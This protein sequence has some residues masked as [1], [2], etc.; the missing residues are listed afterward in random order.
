MV[1][2][3]ISKIGKKKAKKSRSKKSKRKTV[4]SKQLKALDPKLAKQLKQLEK[5]VD[6]F[7]NATHKFLGSALKYASL[8]PKGIKKIEKHVLE[9]TH[10]LESLK[11]HLKK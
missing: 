4:K 7:A 9:A 3:L 8:H 11:K 2:N 1:W 5:E 10:S 6:K